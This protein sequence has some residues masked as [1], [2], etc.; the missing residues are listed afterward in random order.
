MST[1]DSYG[2][3]QESSLP[4][5]LAH[6]RKEERESI[7]KDLKDILKDNKFSKD[8]ITLEERLETLIEVLKAFKNL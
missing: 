8:G 2:Y 4:E 3:G 1:T 7:I 5:L 6:A